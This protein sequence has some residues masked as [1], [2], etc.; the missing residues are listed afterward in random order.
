MWNAPVGKPPHYQAQLRQSVSM[1]GGRVQ[2]RGE[3]W[4]ELKVGGMGTL[5]PPWELTEKTPVR[6]QQLHYIAVLGGVAAFS[7]VLWQLAV[8]Q[9]VP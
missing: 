9:Q 3:G 2:V 1:D 7:N 8:Q 4:Q 6:S 5:C